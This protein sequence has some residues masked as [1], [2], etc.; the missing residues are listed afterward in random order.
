MFFG[1]QNLWFF[2][3]LLGVKIYGFL[4]VFWGD[5]NLRFF[6]IQFLRFFNCFY[7]FFNGFL[8]IF[9]DF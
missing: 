8:F 3:C 4:S 9:D 2:K 7:M 6:G 1:G 5:Q